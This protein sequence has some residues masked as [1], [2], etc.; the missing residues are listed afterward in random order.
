MN[1]E[2]ARVL[3]FEY[4]DKSATKLIRIYMEPDFNQA[5]LDRDMLSD[6]GDEGKNYKVEEVEIFKQ[7]KPTS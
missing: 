4:H 2:V 7:N 5:M 6:F 3:F 1:S